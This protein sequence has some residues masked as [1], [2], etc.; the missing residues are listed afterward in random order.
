MNLIRCCCRSPTPSKHS[1]FL[2]LFFTNVAF[3]L[4]L[5]ISLRFWL[6]SNSVHICQIGDNLEWL[7]PCELWPFFIFLLRRKLNFDVIGPREN[8][9]IVFLGNTVN[10]ANIPG[11]TE[12]FIVILRGITEQMLTNMF[13]LSL[14]TYLRKSFFYAHICLPSDVRHV[15]WFN[16]MHGG[17]CFNFIIYYPKIFDKIYAIRIF[18]M[19]CQN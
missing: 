10:R 11:N 18:H 3:L 13:R 12:L 1:D 7:K 15:A 16:Y 6:A 14:N 2:F 5:S 8:S 9:Q 19:S 17:F 4:F